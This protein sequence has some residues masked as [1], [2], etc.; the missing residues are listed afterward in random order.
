MHFCQYL[1][2]FSG[3]LL[4]ARNISS[5]GTT[6]ITQKE[7][8][9]EYGSSWKWNNSSYDWDIYVHVLDQ[10]NSSGTPYRYASAG[11]IDTCPSTDIEDS[12]TLA[13]RA[14]PIRV[15]QNN[16]IVMQKIGGQTSCKPHVY[17]A[18][19]YYTFPAATA[20]S[21]NSSVSSDTEVPNSICPKGWQLPPNAGNKSYNTLIRT[22]YNISS[23]TSDSQILNSPLSFVRLGDYYYGSGLLDTRGNLGNYW[24]STAYSSNLGHNLYFNSERLSPQDGGG[25]A[26]GYS[27]RCVSR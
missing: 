24:S 22:A 7:N 20:G 25:R 1:P 12:S 5:R 14:K 3:V 19:N 4:G 8:K 26:Y 16:S 11:S 17:N 13:S 23:T 21:N 15:V 6:I 27:V 18:G 2:L 9:G 10:T